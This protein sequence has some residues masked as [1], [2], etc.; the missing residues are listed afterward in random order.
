MGTTPISTH[1]RRK[2][3]AESRSHHI[4]LEHEGYLPYEM[5]LTQ[6]FETGLSIFLPL[7]LN[8]LFV[9]SVISNA[10]DADDET[11][12]DV[13]GLILSSIAASVISNVVTDMVSGAAFVLTV[14]GRPISDTTDTNRHIHVELKRPDQDIQMPRKLLDSLR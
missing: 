4:R 12:A 6:R 3:P 13:G 2:G 10:T 9:I 1:M 8:A 14:N 11:D 5:N 7:L